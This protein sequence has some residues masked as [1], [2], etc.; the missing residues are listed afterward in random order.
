MIFKT[1]YQ[2]FDEQKYGKPKTGRLRMINYL[3]LISMYTIRKSSKT[4]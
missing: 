4:D 2:I 1:S 3:F